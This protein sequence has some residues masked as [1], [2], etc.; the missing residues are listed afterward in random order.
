MNPHWALCLQ[1]PVSCSSQ[2]KP[3]AAPFWFTRTPL[4][5]A[6]TGPFA[7]LSLIDPCFDLQDQMTLKINCDFQDREGHVPKEEVGAKEHSWP[8]LPIPFIPSVLGC[9]SRW[10]LIPEAQNRNFLWKANQK[11]C[12]T[13]KPGA[14]VFVKHNKSLPHLS[15]TSTAVGWNCLCRPHRL[16]SEGERGSLMLLSEAGWCLD[17]CYFRP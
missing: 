12:V 1:T 8:R 4:P 3:Q 15:V 11:D 7:S 17:N 2:K 9:L 6:R 13:Q 16:S 14:L 5:G 10:Q